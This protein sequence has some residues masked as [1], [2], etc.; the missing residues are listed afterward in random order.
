ML[1]MVIKF[2]YILHVPLL[3]S[4]DEQECEKIH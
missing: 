3:T 4:A 1:V 2:F